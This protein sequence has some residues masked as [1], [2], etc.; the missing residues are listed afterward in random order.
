MSNSN[1]ENDLLNVISRHH[2]ATYRELQAALE[3]A[4]GA[5]FSERE[6][7]ASPSH[8]ALRGFQPRLA[9]DGGRTVSPRLRGC[10]DAGA[11]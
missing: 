11:E 1:L 6:I 9:T 8:H 4:A 5:Y 10:N 7:A 3:T 2:D